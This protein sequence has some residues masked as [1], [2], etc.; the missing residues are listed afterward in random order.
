MEGLNYEIG[1][2]TFQFF[3][4]ALPHY[5][6]KPLSLNVHIFNSFITISYIQNVNLYSWHSHICPKEGVKNFRTNSLGEAGSIW[7]LYGTFW[8]QLLKTSGA[9]KMEIKKIFSLEMVKSD[10][11]LGG[12]RK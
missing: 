12:A 11:F 3:H 10:I 8:G 7:G 2:G 4:N 9:L 6:T 1:L 5:P